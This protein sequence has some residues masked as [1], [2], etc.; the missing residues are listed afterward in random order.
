MKFLKKRYAYA[1]IFGL[2]LTASFSY[3][4]LKTFVIAE[5]ISKVSSAIRRPM[6]RLPARLLRQQQ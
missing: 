4:I 1:S 2:L 5:T 6:S 3:S